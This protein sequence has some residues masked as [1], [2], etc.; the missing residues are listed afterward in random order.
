TIY[1][2]CM[3][4]KFNP[5]IASATGTHTGEELAAGN[6]FSALIAREHVGG[7]PRTPGNFGAARTFDARYM[8]QGGVL[9]EGYDIQLDWR[10]ETGGAGALN[11]NV[12]ASILDVY[13]ETAFPGAE[14]SEYTG[15]LFN[16]SYDYR[17]FATLR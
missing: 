15:T 11:L 8:N 16:S 2:Q 4:P 7:Q 14:A 17:T 9:S 5:L 6:P 10:R 12:V 13:S 1:Q 3:D